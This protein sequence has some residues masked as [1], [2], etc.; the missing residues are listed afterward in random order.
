MD[1]NIKSTSEQKVNEDIETNNQI[2]TEKNDNPK[3]RKIRYQKQKVMKL[4]KRMIQKYQIQK[5]RMKSYQKQKA[6]KI[7]KRMIWKYQIQRMGK[8][9]CLK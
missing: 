7:K 2:N 6:R 4:K 8:Q 1:N 5:M 3:K 9:K